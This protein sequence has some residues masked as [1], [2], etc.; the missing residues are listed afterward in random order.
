MEQEIEKSIDMTKQQQEDMIKQTGLSSSLIEEEVRWYL[1]L[2]IKEIKK[3][4]TPK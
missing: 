4:D 1:D 2:V 3:K